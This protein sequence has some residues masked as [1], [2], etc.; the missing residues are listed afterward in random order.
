MSELSLVSKRGLL[1]E[2]DV[3]EDCLRFSEGDGDR[4]K[5]VCSGII[6]ADE[7]IMACDGICE[8]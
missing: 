7:I 3:K 8:G 5:F 6:T 2:S 4:G 1:F